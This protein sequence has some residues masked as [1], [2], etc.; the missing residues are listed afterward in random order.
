MMNLSS[1]GFNCSVDHTVSVVF[2]VRP[3][4]E[5]LELAKMIQTGL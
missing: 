3:E 4:G 1:A 5:F 2:A